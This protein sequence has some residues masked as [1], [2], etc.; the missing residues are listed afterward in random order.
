VSS[1]RLSIHSL[2]EE[3]NTDVMEEEGLKTLGFDRNMFAN[4]NAGRMEET[5]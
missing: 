5:Q 4:L 2:I 3:S 1:G